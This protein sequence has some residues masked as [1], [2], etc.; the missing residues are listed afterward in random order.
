MNG[1]HTSN[2]SHRL[3]I[4]PCRGSSCRSLAGTE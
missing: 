2:S 1:Q 3:T 4:T